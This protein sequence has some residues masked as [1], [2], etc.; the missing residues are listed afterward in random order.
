MITMR[1][2]LLRCGE[3]E[4]P[5]GVTK[6]FLETAGD[7]LLAAFFPGIA[8]DLYQ[9]TMAYAYWKCGKHE[10]SAAFD[11][12]FRK[13]PFNGEFAVFA[14]LNDVLQIAKSF[15]L[16]SPEIRFLRE[17]MP[18]CEEGFYKWLAAADCS[19]VRI[20]AMPE[21]MLAFP[22]VP[23]IRVE[24]PLAVIQLLETPFLNAT[25]FATLVATN[26]ARFRLAAGVNKTLLE[27][28][29]RRAQGPNGALS[30]SRFSYL[31]GFDGT[32]NVLASALFGIPAKGTHAHSFVLSFTDGD[33]RAYRAK[34]ALFAAAERYAEAIAPHTNKSELT[35]FV[36]YASAFPDGFLALVD[37]YDTLKSGVPN[38]LA[39]ALA[40][41]E[42][43]HR[44][45]GIR[46]D[47]GDL[48]Y[49]SKESRRMFCEAAKR[50]N[51][52]ELAE[53]TIAA[54]N[55]INEEVLHELN[56]Q[57]HEINTFGIGTNLVTCQAQ[58]ALGGVYKLMESAGLPRIKLSNELGKITIPARKHVFRLEGKEG[59][60]LA[61]IMMC[62]DEKMPCTGEPI[63]CRDPFSEARRVNIIPAVVIPL[64][65][66]VW[67]G[68]RVVAPQPLAVSREF[69]LTQLRRMRQDHLRPVNPTPY[70]VTVSDGL[71]QI[72]HRLWTDEAPVEYIE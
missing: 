8:T 7:A 72:M 25:N 26:A 17:T 52:P 54:S 46:L 41:R 68:G 15:P 60:P 64:H 42:S 34:N 22:R 4:M 27:F 18:P 30:A 12:F 40:L 66:L 28:G 71:W 6:E 36:A 31:G 20:S 13:C 9:F 45:I 61:D 53:L 59:H 33:Y 1:D 43:G 62:N 50:F 35:A 65:H 57:G 58:P 16:Q 63:L 32:S 29:I 44:A 19:K 38:F 24:G 14:G 37:T 10:E 67:F 2:V 5:I 39:A 49:L 56:R 21:G 47:S 55:D 69:V 23:L 51:A 3:D 70:K 11:L 48:A